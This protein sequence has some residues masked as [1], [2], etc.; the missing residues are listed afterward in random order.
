MNIL[1][2]VA[3]R[4]PCPQCDACYD[5]PL[6]DVLLSHEI[7]AHEGCPASVEGES[8]CPPAFQ[9]RLFSANEVRLFEEAWR[10]L[11]QHARGDGGE[12]VLLPGGAPSRKPAPP[13]SETRHSA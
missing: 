13:R 2:C 7:I 1:D 12:L 6:R 9:R 11:E 8:E 4:L 3:I 10:R 5:V